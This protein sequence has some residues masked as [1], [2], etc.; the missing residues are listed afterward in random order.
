[1]DKA[2]G[3][4]VGDVGLADFKRA[5]EPSI[6]GVPELGWVL[7]PSVHGR[8]YATEAVQAVSAW[9]DQ[10]L[11]GAR[12]VCI[13]DPEYAASL[14]VAAKCGFREVVRTTYAGQPTILFERLKKA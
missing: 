1:V 12:T 6:H 13:I 5:M 10:Q 11:D 4:Y 9:G 3:L 14:K 8:G 2:S 7:H